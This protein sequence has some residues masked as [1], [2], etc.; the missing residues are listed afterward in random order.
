MNKI[1]PGKQYLVK[2]SGS[3]RFVRRAF[4]W[5][6][7]RFNGIKCYVFTSRL[8]NGAI[9]SGDG[10]TFTMTVKGQSI[11]RELSI[12]FYDLIDIKPAQ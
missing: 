8:S 7:Q 4:K 10:K 2:H 9:T 5:T 3:K 11:R 12:P 6:E 1:E